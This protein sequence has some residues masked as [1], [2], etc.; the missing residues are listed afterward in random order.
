MVVTKLTF[1][2][3]PPPP[4]PMTLGMGLSYYADFFGHTV[5]RFEDYPPAFLETL[6]QRRRTK[7]ELQELRLSLPPLVVWRREAAARTI[8]AYW[9]LEEA[10]ARWNSV[11]TLAHRQAHPPV[12]GFLP[13]RG[14]SL[15]LKQAQKRHRC[16]I[17][18]DDIGQSEM[19][20]SAEIPGEGTYNG[21]I[22]ACA[23]CLC[24]TFLFLGVDEWP[25]VEH[26]G[27]IPELH[28]YIGAGE[29]WPDNH[30]PFSYPNTAD[31]IEFLY[32][33]Q[34]GGQ[35]DPNR[36][37]V[38]GRQPGLH[39]KHHHFQQMRQHE[40]I[41][42]TGADAPGWYRLSEA[43]EAAAAC[44]KAEISEAQPG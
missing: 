24:R 32:G 33:L 8:A 7:E 40:W 21:T 19:Y 36:N 30:A 34:D 23:F 29:P 31:Q 35:I 43:G 9:A 25:V 11:A 42:P 2:A 38:G 4:E 37:I 17:G 41:E 1:I 3:P 26:Q 6:N 18:Q 28:R 44:I 12:P 20:A 39:L 14:I 15:H 5:H 27:Y 10:V 16:V 22:A 13:Q